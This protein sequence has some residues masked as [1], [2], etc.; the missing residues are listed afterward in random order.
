MHIIIEIYYDIDVVNG[1][2][3]VD[4]GSSNVT[5]CV[6]ITGG[7]LE[8]LRHSVV[9]LSTSDVSAIGGSDYTSVDNVPLVFTSDIRRLCHVIDI[10]NNEIYEDDEEFDVFLT[11][12]DSSAVLI[13]NTTTITITDND[14]LTIGFRGSSPVI[15]SE[16]VGSL[17]LCFNISRGAIDTDVSITVQSN[18]IDATVNEDYTVPSTSSLSFNGSI[19]IQCYHINIRDDSTYETNEMF[20]LILSSI[21]PRI[22]FDTQPVQ[23]IIQ[24]NDM[25]T[26]TFDEVN[27]VPEDTPSVTVCVQL[28][29]MDNIQRDVIVLLNTIEGTARESIDYDPLVNVT[30]TFTPSSSNKTC[31]NVALI[32]NNAADGNKLFSIRMTST[33]PRV[34]L[35][36]DL[37]IQLLDDD[38]SVIHGVFNVCS[39]H[40]NKF[41]TTFSSAS[42]LFDKDCEY[43]L[44][45]SCDLSIANID[46]RVDLS[47]SGSNTSS[48]QIVVLYNGHRVDILQGS[49][50]LSSGITDD[51]NVR[52]AN[53]NVMVIIPAI[54]VTLIY[55][56]TAD[57]IAIQVNSNSFPFNGLCG[58]FDGD[59]LYSDCIRKA[60]RSDLSTLNNFIDSY[61]VQPP[62]QI[63]KPNREECGLVKNDTVIGD[64]L[65]TVP[66]NVDV[67]GLPLQKPLYLC[68]EIHGEPNKYFNFISDDC[69]SVTAHYF[70]PSSVSHLNII[71]RISI[72]AVDDQMRCHK[73]Q[74]DL[75]ECKVTYDNNPLLNTSSNGTASQTSFKQN[76]I[77]LRR[78]N[79]NKIRVKVPNCADVSL[80][81]WITCENNEVFDPYTYA[82]MGKVDMIKFVVARGFNLNEYSHGLLG[83]FWNVPMNVTKYNGPVNE[84]IFSNENMY[85]VTVNHP[86]D[87]PRQFVAM[88]YPATWGHFNKNCLYAGSNQGGPIGEVDSPNDP[89]IRGKYLHYIVSNPFDV[90]FEY[91]VFDEAA[92]C[93]NN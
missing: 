51:I 77:T 39:L 90:R 11:S 80:A 60:N 12:N 20:Q 29:S 4:E 65:L 47:S 14:G 45:S 2:I 61:Y 28:H 24:D 75:D 35:D 69:T 78:Y 70:K 19:Q 16:S 18:P 74:V 79:T 68:Y 38:T 8:G 83:Q 57:S 76:G 27:P 31:R 63:I 72:M 92:V 32:G 37:L 73:I 53:G 50:S 40:P 48:A 7:Q 71:D 36:N 54:N 15:V 5:V 46:I 33:S 10:L 49:A 23:V 84:G 42:Y 89:V 25:V 17:D 86:T 62:D 3:R 81:M 21:H 43:K 82:S 55:N 93:L 1:G 30:L 22:S 87:P 44:F 85:T 56:S 26:L 59:F 6:N 91:S 41:I 88:Y 66:I 64:P 13:R 52:A 9:T 34:N 58:G 67:T